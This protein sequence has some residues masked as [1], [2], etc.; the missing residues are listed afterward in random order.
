MVI[1]NNKTV[2]GKDVF[3][4]A[5]MSKEKVIRICNEC[6][7][8]KEVQWGDIYRCRKKHNRTE[9]YCFKCSMKIYNTGANNSSKKSENAAK[10]SAATRGKSKTF[11]DGKN[12]RILDR[13]VNTG[14]YILKWDENSKSHILE[15]RYV[16]ANHYNINYNDLQEIHHLDGNKK[17]NSI[18]NLIE[19]S[20]Q[21]HS[22]LHSQLEDL[23][24]E[25]VRR[26]QIIFDKKDKKYRLN[27]AVELISMDVSYGFED[28]AITQQKNICN[29]RLDTDITSEII[30]GVKRNIPMIASNMSTV[31]N[32]DFY[33]KL[34]KLGAFG[35][36]H[37]AASKEF[38]LNEIKKVAAE[39][40]WVA[41][42]VGIEHD[43]FEFSKEMIRCG[44][45]IVV[46]DIAH[47]YSDPILNLAKQIKL[48]SPNT[49]LVIGNTT[50][51][52]LVYKC[53][54]FVDAIKLGIAQGFACETK[55]TA[56]CTEKQFSA[57]LKFKHIAKNFGIPII[58]D[59]SIREPADLVK[60]I[61]AG[62]NSIMAGKIFA[63]CPESAAETELVYD[64][65]KKVYAGM[66]SRYVQEQWKG[67]LKSGTCPEGGIRYLDIGESAEK[68][69][70][71]YSGALRSG[72]TYAGA[73]DIDSF[74]A[75]VRFIRFAK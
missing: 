29:S 52:D 64:V 72:I 53:Y 24:F 40:Q 46:I 42:S 4:L 30:R 34:Y 69:L 59:G 25:L 50:N 74:Q 67:K 56:G 9:D 55:N 13:K 20:N 37:R 7:N 27:S 12:L 71:R 21:D 3:T 68:L 61:G 14:G 65:P 31:I 75:N 44:C 41:A 62:A 60:S 73:K 6:G 33:I 26:G 18:D 28:V 38:I 43:Q 32:S 16:Y 70:E 66:A 10:I 47:G 17:N 49:K 19:L 35:I 11:K 22:L 48:F 5:K 1:E 36:L 57:I 45:N 51:V 2:S 58:S 63:A 54:E 8:K 15:H 23:A 39:C